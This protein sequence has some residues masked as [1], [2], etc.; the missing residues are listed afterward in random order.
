MDVYP[1]SQNL[2]R[3]SFVGDKLVGETVGAWLSPGTVGV[4]VVGLNVVGADVGEVVGDSVRGDGAAV[5][6]AGDSDGSN[7]GEAVGAF[8]HSSAQVD[9]L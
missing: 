9:M 3:Q 5:G 7:E 2:S 1:T 8:R 6:T 4:F